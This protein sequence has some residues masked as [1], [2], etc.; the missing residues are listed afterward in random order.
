MSNGHKINNVAKYLGG[1]TEVNVLQKIICAPH[2]E[3]FFTTEEEKC[4]TRP[5]QCIHDIYQ[6][7]PL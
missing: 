3:T 1:Y 2:E 6:P 4:P 5:H 7:Y